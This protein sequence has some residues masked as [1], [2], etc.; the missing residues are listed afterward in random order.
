MLSETKRGEKSS[1][2]SLG[3]E[4]GGDRRPS[5]V[6]ECVYTEDGVQLW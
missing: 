1:P 5:Q 2:P 3:A 6:P 4:K